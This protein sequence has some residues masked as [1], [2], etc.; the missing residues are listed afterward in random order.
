VLA[1]QRQDLERAL[2]DRED[3][4]RLAV[5]RSRALTRRAERLSGET[6][7]LGRAVADGSATDPEAREEGR[8]LLA[9]AEELSSALGDAPE[10]QPARR[11]LSD[12]VMEALY[13]VERK[14]MSPRLSRAT[15]APGGP[16]GIRP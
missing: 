4:D 8:R 6:F 11:M 5:L 14:A 2:A 12:A 16:P 9:E 15:G 7:A 10:L 1:I 13:A 3:A